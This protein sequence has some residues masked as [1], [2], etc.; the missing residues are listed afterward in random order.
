MDDLLLIQL[1][2]FQPHYKRWKKYG[3]KN[4]K[5]KEKLQKVLWESTGGYCMYCYSRVLVDRKLFG[6]LEHAIEKSN[7]KK[8][9]ECIPNI[10][11]A[12]SICNQSFK[13]RAEHV[14]KLP[15]DVLTEYETNSR[16]TLEKR[17]QCTVPCK[18]LKKV[19]RCY[20]QLPGAQIILQPMG[21]NGWDSGEP[22]AL[23]FDVLS[24]CFQPAVSGH[25]YSEQEIQYIEEHI[26]RFHLNDPKYRTKSLFEFVKQVIDHHGILSNYEYNNWLVEQFAKMLSDRSQEEALKLCEAIYCSTFLKVGN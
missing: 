3:Y 17:K 6:N 8:L 5:E 10:G 14:R 4:P 23:Q 13:R 19:R 1:P 2:A 21:V 15:E 11:L 16:C 26:R 20:S 18:A 25:S 12:C 24:M 22:L 7:S 9:T